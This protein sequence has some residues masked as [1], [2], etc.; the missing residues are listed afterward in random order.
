LP[1]CGIVIGFKLDIFHRCVELAKL[2]FECKKPSPN[3]E[4]LGAEYFDLLGYLYEFMLTKKEWEM[5]LAR[6][7]M[8]PAVDKWKDKGGKAKAIDMAL[9][10]HDEGLVRL[11]DILRI[12]KLSKKD[13]QAALKAR[14][15]VF[16][17]E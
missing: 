7:E 5:V 11:S 13:F 10:L 14:D 16:Q 8:K 1:I 6:K 12:A 9:Q 4:K 3:N 15:E 17:P 2:A